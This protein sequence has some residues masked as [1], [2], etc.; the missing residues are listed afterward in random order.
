M[1][2]FYYVS[3]GVILQKQRPIRQT[4]F[5]I[6]CPSEITD[7]FETIIGEA[8]TKERAQQIA[9]ALNFA[10]KGGKSTSEAK[11]KASAENGKKGGRPKKTE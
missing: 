3:K 5:Y 11:R 9:D 6:V 10:S 7:G 8:Y 1:T 4:V 2:R